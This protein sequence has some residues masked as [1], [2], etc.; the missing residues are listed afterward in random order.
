VGSAAAICG[1]EL[2]HAGVAHAASLKVPLGLQLYS[3]RNL[4]P[5]DYAGTLK[6][7]GALGYHE[8]E[9]AGYYGHSVA[10]VSQALQ[11]AGLKL[12]SAHYSSDDLNK[13]F[14][15]ILAFNKALG[16]GTIICSM[17]AYKDPSRLEKIAP[18]DRINAY[19]LEDWSFNADQFNKWGERV[20]AAGMKFGYHN[21][22]MEFRATAEGL[23]PFKELL[24]LTDPTKV[25][26]EMDCGWV[27]VGGGDP[28]E[29]LRNYPT[30][31]SML[32][33]KDFKHPDS[34]AQ[35]GHGNRIAELGQ[36]YIDYRPVFE[37][38]AK[39]GH[40]THCFVEQEGFDMPPMD[41]LKV[42]ADYMRGLGIS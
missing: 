17:P 22:Y 23:V 35:N 32:H 4:L 41:S 40:V 34:A 27:V 8:V 3:V 15:D 24:R 5:T 2:F 37:E 19:T 1:P 39:A 26:M 21:H 36:G 25:T 42:D 12:V 11:D 20:Q 10:E 31:I 14:D 30:R 16:V 7:I 6:Q 9:A 28:V 33:V 18:R 29:Y 13:Q 38:A